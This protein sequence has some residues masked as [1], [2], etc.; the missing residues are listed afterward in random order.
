MTAV[1]RLTPAFADKLVKVLG[2]L[3]SAHDG[4]VAAAG[5][6]AHSMLKAMGLTWGDVIARAPPKPEP[7][8]QSRAPR[9]WRRP[10]SPSD[11]A[12]LC[13]LWPEV[14][15][16]WETNFCRSIVGRRRIS[17]KQSV[18][19]ERI[20]RKVEAFARATGEWG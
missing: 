5:R 10:T 12:A 7:Q 14:L 4:E 18:V 11:T 13:L 6:R 2:M 15:T 17:A 20:A 1:P 16:D 3:G 9:R 8:R 19:L